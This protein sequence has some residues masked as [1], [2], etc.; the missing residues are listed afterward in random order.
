[1]E[2]KEFVAA[3]LAQI[4]EG[5]QLAQSR[6]KTTSAVVNPQLDSSSGKEGSFHRGTGTFIRE[7]E[8]DVAVT[9][10]EASGTKGGV[11]I[12]VG[13]IGLGSQGQS[14]AA[15]TQLSRIKFAV[16]LLLPRGE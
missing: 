16:P 2:L 9:T 1:M 7:I 11:G 8:F 14:D 5:V 10:M 4:V 12:F 15:K 3:T 13:A 6:T